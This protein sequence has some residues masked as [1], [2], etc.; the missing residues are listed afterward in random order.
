MKQELKVL[1]AHGPSRED[2]VAREQEHLPRLPMER[3]ESKLGAGQG[4]S[5]EMSA[6]ADMVAKAAAPSHIATKGD[7][8]H[9]G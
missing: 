6:L 3:L 2:H 7:K 1:Q 8:K 4:R 5:E 9:M